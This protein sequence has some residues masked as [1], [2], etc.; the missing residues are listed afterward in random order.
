MAETQD[1][2]RSM[3][4]FFFYDDLSVEDS[5]LHDALV[6]LPQKKRSLF[7]YREG[8]AGLDQHVNL[9]S[10]AF[11]E[12]MIRYDAAAWFGQRNRTV[13]DG[14]DGTKDRRAATSQEV[15]DV[16]RLGD[17]MEVA[18]PIVPFSELS[19]PRTARVSIGGVS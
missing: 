12:V 17:G 9:P 14:T 10:G 19:E 4:A 8:S 11:A 7:Y 6:G 18:V 5:I 2:L 3:D 1:S 15:I 16:T 13:G